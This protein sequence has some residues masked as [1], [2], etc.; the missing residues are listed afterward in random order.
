MHKDILLKAPVE[1]GFVPTHAGFVTAL[2][3]G[4]DGRL[5]RNPSGELEVVAAVREVMERARVVVPAVQVPVFPGAA[6]GEWDK[7]VA[8]LRAMG[9]TVHLVIMLGGVDP[10]DPADED[11][12]VAQL[13]AALAEALRN[14]VKHVSATSVEQWMK[15]GARR[16]EGAEFDAAIEQLVKVHLRAYEEAGLAGSCVE[17]WHIEFLRPGEFQT[18]TELGRLWTFV[19]TINQRL[20]RDF[21]KCL[22]DAAHCGDSSLDIPANQ[23]LIAEIAA[24]G[25]L[26]IM[27][28]SAKT[29]RG[30]LSS[31]DGWV[32]ALISAGAA[33]GQLRQVFVEM[34]DHA[35]P[36]LAPL[37]QM[38]PR[39]GV[40][41]RD[42]RD[43]T[44][45][46]ADGLDQ[47]A[48]MLNNFVV[49]GMLPPA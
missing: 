49:R 17:A 43:Y 23:A 1:L 25:G 14:G 7:V 3:P 24:G 37:R 6:E 10:M 33:S 9:L 30:C 32:A 22:I 28:A 38:D 41:T 20:G 42:G 29:T 15:E 8:E 31:D 39:H 48:R 36:A 11:A 12:T 26:G 19:R 4:G 45:V 47:T 40:D 21:F 44:Q 5:P 13:L 2:V 18:F 35:D 27:H 16:K 34:F 46:V